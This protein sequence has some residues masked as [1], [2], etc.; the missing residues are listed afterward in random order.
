MRATAPAF[1]LL[2]VLFGPCRIDSHE[3]QDS[4]NATARASVE[5][6]SAGGASWQDGGLEPIAIQAGGYQVIQ[7][8]DGQ[9]VA[10]E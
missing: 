3:D 2:V 7:T 4:A 9:V 1:A 8:S 6:V 10:F 5:I